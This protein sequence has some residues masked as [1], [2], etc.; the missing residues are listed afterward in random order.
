MLVLRVPYH[1]NNNYA[2]QNGDLDLN[3]T[4]GDHS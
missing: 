2:E 4:E 1:R 3:Q